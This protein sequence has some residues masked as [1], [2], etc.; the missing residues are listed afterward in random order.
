MAI[1]DTSMSTGIAQLDEV[2]QGIRP[3]DNIVWK[4]DFLE[5]YIQYVHPFCIEAQITSGDMKPS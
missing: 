3:G 1:F 2:I 4:L 5:D